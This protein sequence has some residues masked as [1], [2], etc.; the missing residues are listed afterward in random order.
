MEKAIELARASGVGVVGVRNSSHCGAI[1]LYTRQ[2]TQAQMIGLAFTHSDSFVVPQGGKEPFFGTNPISIAIPTPNPDRPLCLDMA[3]SVV[4]LNRIM[5][6]RRENQPLEPGWAVDKNGVETID[7]HAVAGVLPM[8]GHKGYAM[9]FLIDMLCGPLNGMKYGPHLND[10]YGELDDHRCLGSLMLA[11]DPARFFGGTGLATA[12]ISAIVDVKKQDR[13]ILYPGEPE[14]LSE[15]R[16]TKSGIPIDPGLWD[17]FAD[18]SGRLG[19][20][21]PTTVRP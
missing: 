4:P 11:I 5:N 15:E 10:M 6:A 19:I 12:I 16:R 9:A 13:A 7:P 17:E 18:W 14:Y 8:A 1:G 21:M 20:E 2:A 3:T